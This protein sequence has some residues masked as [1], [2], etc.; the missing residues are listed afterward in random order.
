MS[1]VVIG[2]SL[3]LDDKQA[4]QSMKSFKQQLKEANNDLISMSDKFGLASKEAQTAAK[5]VAEMKDALGDAKALAD[6]FNPDRKFQA[7]SV[8][9]RGVTNGFT[10]MQGVMGLVGSESEDL[11]KTL[12]KVQ[13]ALALSEGVNGLLEMKDGFKIV[14]SVAVNAFQ[15]IKAAITSTG[16]LA[17]AVIIGSIVAYWDDI[18]EAVT[19]VS[20]EMKEQAAAAKANA[21]VEREKLKSLDSQDNIL[22]LQGKSEKEILNYK[23]KQTEQAIQKTEIELEAN[24]ANLKAQIEAEKKNR[25]ILRGILDFTGGGL[26]VILKGVDWIGKILGK[27]WGLSDK[28]N[29]WITKQV[30]NPEETEKKGQEEIKKIDDTLNELRNKKA[31]FQLS[32]QGIDKEAA[33]KSDD[34]AKESQ[35]KQEET[36]QQEITQRERRHRQEAEAAGQLIK[37]KWAAEDAAKKEIADKEAAMVDA[38]KNIDTS[39]SGIIGASP[40]E[41][42]L[43]RSH[44]LSQSEIKIAA[45][46]AEYAALISLA[47][48]NEE[49]LTKLKREH[50]EKRNEIDMIEYENKVKMQQATSSVLSAASDLLGRETTAGKIFA[51][52][53]ATIDTY[54]AIAK[55]LKAYSGVPIPGFA[56]AQSIATGLTGLAA[57]KNILKVQV[58]NKGGS[59]GGGSAPSL[60][61]PSAPS[62]PSSSPL[63]TS[64]GVQRTVIDQDQVNQMGSA[65]AR[66]YIVESDVTS[67]QERI[68]RLNRAAKLG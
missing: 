13:S 23:I 19:G 38:S 20:E 59:G 55:T 14:Q 2:A 46:D 41:Q 62:V 63:L 49:T 35:K 27:N 22:K 25:D 58:P 48:T 65:A 33:K 64:P 7:F 16:I 37:D 40:E 52:A 4:Q 42:E 6:A 18:K 12:V 53:A 5:K 32:I 8:A 54:S 47:G 29:G 67:G 30:F 11:Q 26:N 10:A 21:E 68:T 28:L 61:M 66:A 3:Q 50:Q 31:G 56:I 44:L 39:K 9:I 60:S 24:K 45:L 36:Y 43:L 17:F 34:L 57:V 1:D 15:K 51:V